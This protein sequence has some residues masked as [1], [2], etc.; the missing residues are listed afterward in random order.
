M[1][2]LEFRM[3][4][5]QESCR[6][7]V[8][9][10]QTNYKD[11]RFIEIEGE[12]T[13]NRIQRENDFLNGDEYLQKMAGR[14]IVPLIKHYVALRSNGFDFSEEPREVGDR[15]AGE[16]LKILSN[17]TSNCYPSFGDQPQ[18]KSL[19]EFLKVYRAWND[20]PP[21]LW[22]QACID[23]R[24]FHTLVA[25][26]PLPVPPRERVIEQLVINLRKR[27]LRDDS[28][29]TEDV[30]LTWKNTRGIYSEKVADFLFKCL[31]EDGAFDPVLSAL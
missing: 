18:G 2:K 8:E 1:S 17:S 31:Y 27:R 29:L 15:L 16:I 9:R 13:L 14:C 28:S 5:V 23:W 26:H 30:P 6:E 4:I 10:Y 12:T 21:D 22:Y 11:G 7:L 25:T 20:N 19:E 24:Q 3:D